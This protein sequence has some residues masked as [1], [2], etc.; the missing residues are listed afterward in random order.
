MDVDFA[1]I[2]GHRLSLLMRVSSNLFFLARRERILRGR[3]SVPRRGVSKS[4]RSGAVPGTPL[5]ALRQF[6]HIAPSP[7]RTPAEP[8]IN[9]NIHPLS[10]NGCVGRWRTM[11]LVRLL[12]TCVVFH[13][14]LLVYLDRTSNIAPKSAACIDC[15]R[16]Q[17]EERELPVCFS[18]S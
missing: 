7:A 16:E 5:W 2:V 13:T 6:L 10:R 11:F 15:K 12:L 4:N 17:K 3:C 18:R 14:T 8:P 9:L 1:S